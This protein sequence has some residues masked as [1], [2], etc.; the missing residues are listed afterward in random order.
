MTSGDGILQVVVIECIPECS[1]EIIRLESAVLVFCV[2]VNWKIKIGTR[3]IYPKLCQVN[4]GHD[5]GNLELDVK[6]HLR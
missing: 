5:G 6:T 2:F 4:V 1:D 3:Y